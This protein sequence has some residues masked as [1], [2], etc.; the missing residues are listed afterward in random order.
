MADTGGAA[1]AGWYPDPSGARVLRYWDGTTWTTHRA[2]MGLATPPA[3][4]LRST[5]SAARW[6]RPAFVL[7]P[8]LVLV[9]GLLSIDQLHELVERFRADDFDGTARFDVGFGQLGGLLSW[10]LLFAVGWWSYQA[11]R[12]GAALGLPQRREPGWALAGWLV[13][14]INLWFPV[15]SVRRFVPDDALTPR[16]WWWWAARIVETVLAWSV[17]PVGAFGGLS[18]AWPL[19][20]AEVLVALV[21][22]LL[23]WT[24]VDRVVA[25]QGERAVELGL[26]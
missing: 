8:V 7:E 6:A 1:P 2:P 3:D 22:G 16:L 26:A 23:G 21:F 25:L 10:G 12:S 24:I 4:A 18:A 17:L 11:A 20:T 9:V 15:Q 14:V 19:L 13:P 5:R